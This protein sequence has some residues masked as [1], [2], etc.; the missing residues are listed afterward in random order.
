MDPFRSKLR[1][2]LRTFCS[3][4]LDVATAQSDP[5]TGGKQRAKG[6]D[7][8]KDSVLPIITDLKNLEKD[9]EL[10]DATLHSQR[11]DLVRRMV[12]LTDPVLLSPVD[13]ETRCEALTLILAPRRVIGEKPW[14]ELCKS[15]V[16][17]F[18]GGKHYLKLKGLASWADREDIYFRSTLHEGTVIVYLFIL[19]LCGDNKLVQN[20]ISS[21]SHHKALIKLYNAIVDILCMDRIASEKQGEGES[22]SFDKDQ[23]L[24]VNAFL[25]RHSGYC[26]VQKDPDESDGEPDAEEDEGLETNEAAVMNFVS[27]L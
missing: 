21:P 24:A 27:N 5:K 20:F 8:V 22:A 1:K 6:I 23:V 14:L 10:E 26:G 17:K 3:E 12:E 18:P 16:R 4:A 13:K 25:S 9:T 19:L 7:V 11:K 15:L 2:F